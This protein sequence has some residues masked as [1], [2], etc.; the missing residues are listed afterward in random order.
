MN[1]WLKLASG[2]CLVACAFIPAQA[3]D[4][5][6]EG[7]QPVS[8]LEALPQVVRVRCQ[9]IEIDLER[10]PAELVDEVSPDT[11]EMRIFRDE[12]NRNLPWVRP[13]DPNDV[14]QLLQK[15][16]KCGAAK[17]MAEPTI[18]VVEGQSGETEIVTVVPA[19]NSP[20]A[21]AYCFVSCTFSASPWRYDQG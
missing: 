10:I 15:L 9:A 4:V 12:R 20:I 7:S 5:P 8:A 19:V 21:Q 18:S 1:T 17:I 16:V 14:Q 11:D 2:C 3:A 6:S 13:A